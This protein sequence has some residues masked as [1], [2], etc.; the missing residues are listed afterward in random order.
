MKIFLTLFIL[1]SL[2]SSSF[3]DPVK[4]WISSVQDKKYYED[5]LVRYKSIDPDFNAEVTAFGFMEMPDK[6]SVAMK[7]G[8]GTPD[9]VQLDEVV[10]SMFLRGQVPFVD[11]S[12]RVKKADIA[13]DFHPQRLNLFK[14]GEQLFG[15]PQSL[16]AYVLYYRKDLFDQYGLTP[17]DINTWE[18]LKDIGLELKAEG[19]KTMPLDPSY[20]EVLLRQQGGRLFD[21]KGKALPDF[22]LAVKTLEYIADLQKNEVAVMPDRGTVFDP[23]FFSGD[24]A[25]NEILAI[26]G[27]DWYGLD[28]LQSFCPELK[29]KWGIAPLPKW[30]KAKGKSYDSATFAGQGL[31][32]YKGSKQVDKSW[33][34]MKWVMTDK[35]AN[36]ARFTDRNSF[37]AYKPVWSDPRLLAQSEY[38]SNEPLGLTV[39]QVSQE[40]PAIS[41]NAKRGMAVFLM[42]EKYFA[43]VMMG[44]QTAT[45]ALTELKAALD[46]PQGQGPK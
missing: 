12:E 9:I 6:L 35:E 25:N 29:G 7:T 44:H 18:K 31:M 33:E 32:I 40:L 43:S 41:M 27:A 22:K 10:Y 30:A 15:L 39:L 26:V 42:R 3:A 34:F 17:D 21:E 23:V 38:F 37:P 4:I 14:Q 2:A 5:M 16:S 45:E 19:Q 20:F 8:V 11:I 46:N 1:I 36:V 24:V 28:M 13:K